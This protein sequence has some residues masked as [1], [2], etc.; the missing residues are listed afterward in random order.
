M[1]IAWLIGSVMESRGH[2][3]LFEQ[4]KPEALEALRQVAIIQSAESSNRIEGVTVDRDRL[5]PLVLGRARPKDRPEHEVVGYRRA[6]DWIH[7]HHDRITVQPKTLSRLHELSQQASGDAGQLKTT[8]NDIIEILPD[9]HRRL[10][11]RTVSV[12]ETPEALEQLCIAYGHTLEQ[13]ALPPI[14]VAASLVLDFLCIHPF[15]D[16]NGRVA[17]LLTLLALY[18]QGFLV[19]RFVSLERLIEESKESY[20]ET[21][22]QSSQGWH[23]G[24]HDPTHWWSYFA[25]T[26]RQA[27]Q[28]FESSIEGIDTER[29]AKSSLV[30]RAINELPDEFGIAEVVALCPGVSR[31]LIRRSLRARRDQGKLESV[32]TGRGAKWRKV[33]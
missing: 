16:G 9:G 4:Q 3:Q 13:A 22:F 10:R 11:F 7:G 12:E 21:L 24:S 27:Y 19:G 32:G 15:R 23:T 1:G 28:T 14:I 25:S 26:I 6:L 20:Y 31:S 5:E 2:Q 29:G 18:R 33:R 17:R 30:E 8:N